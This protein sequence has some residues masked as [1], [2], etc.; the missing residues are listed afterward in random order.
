MA[1]VMILDMTHMKEFP[2]K[3][4]HRRYKSLVR[5]HQVWV[6]KRSKNLKQEPD[7]VYNHT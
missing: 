5:H 7:L 1:I 6:Y 3:F 4:V 2:N